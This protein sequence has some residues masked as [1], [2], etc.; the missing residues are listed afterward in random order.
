MVQQ[1]DFGSD[2]SPDDADNSFAPADADPDYDGPADADP[3]QPQETYPELW[4]KLGDHD[5]DQYSWVSLLY[6]WS[7]GLMKDPFSAD[8]VVSSCYEGL[9]ELVTE[10]DF[11]VQD[12]LVLDKTLK[13]FDFLVYYPAK[14]LQE[15]ENVYEQCGGYNYLVMLSLLFGFDYG[16]I[17]ELVTRISLI[18]SDE[19]QGF[20]TDMYDLFEEE[21][22]DWYFV[23][24]RIGLFWK[25][26]FDV[27][28]LPE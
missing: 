21:F 13:F 16:Y 5:I 27:E 18:V 10:A 9:F 28:L 8:S 14:L 2:D 20:F 15:S 17:A 1:D 6:G 25:K 23:G 26:V 19:A 7:K 24:F 4:L 3:D 11:F 22:T 12:V